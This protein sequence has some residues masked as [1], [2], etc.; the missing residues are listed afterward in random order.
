[1]RSYYIYTIYLRSYIRFAAILPHITS[2][3]TNI[4]YYF[5]YTQYTSPYHPPGPSPYIYSS[6]YYVIRVAMTDCV[7]IVYMH[8]W[9]AYLC[10]CI[11]FQNDWGM[12]DFILHLTVAGLRRRRYPQNR[13]Y[14]QNNAKWQLK[15]K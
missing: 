4:I 8:I 1:M 6:T 12:G 13:K 7:R 10:H 9:C 14:T 2:A 3:L 15:R 11:R 5:T